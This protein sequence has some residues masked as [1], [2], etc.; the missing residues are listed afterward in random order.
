MPQDSDPAV[1]EQMP[2]AAQ[3]LIKASADLYARV[4]RLDEGHATTSR[5]RARRAR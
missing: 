3:R 5:C 4:E 1:V 2:D